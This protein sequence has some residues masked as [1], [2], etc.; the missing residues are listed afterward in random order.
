VPQ[1]H[2]YNCLL[3][4][5]TVYLTTH[6]CNC[7]SNRNID[8]KFTRQLGLLF[9]LRSS[10][11]CPSIPATNSIMLFDEADTLA[12]LA[13]LGTFSVGISSVVLLGGAK[14]TWDNEVGQHHT[15]QW[16]NNDTDSDDR[17]SSHSVS[18]TPLHLT[19]TP[20]N[21]NL[22]ASAVALATSLL[23]ICRTAYILWWRRQRKVGHT[24]LAGHVSN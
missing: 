5:L 17:G 20:F 8:R 21:L 11:L 22:A 18:Y 24:Y 12:I 7:S 15:F 9:L 3:Q 6:F 16:T 4:L 10:Q 23:A 14:H 1:L 2:G 19:W 13:A